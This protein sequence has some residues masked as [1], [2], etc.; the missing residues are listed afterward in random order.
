MSNQIELRQLESFLTL[1]KEL[2]FRR[3][4]E[5]LFISQPGLSKQM[6]QLEQQL[7]VT[8]LERDRRNVRLTASGVYL[9]TQ[10]ENILGLLDQTVTHIKHLENGLEGELKIGFV[11]SAMQQ[12]IP[13]LIKKCNTHYPNLRFVLDEMSNQAQVEAIQHYQIDLGFVRLNAVPSDVQLKPIFKEHFSLVLPKKHPITTRKFQGVHQLK[14]EPFILF[15][16]DY[17]SNYYNNIMSIFADAGFTPKVSHKS[18]HANTIFRLV[19]NG[20]GVAIVP[21]SLTLGATKAIAI[22]IVDLKK[23]RQRAVLSIAWKKDR[24]APALEKIL[25]FFNEVK[26]EKV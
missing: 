16:S 14:E 19:E 12:V 25:R 22:K 3:A 4:A 23:N 7:E 8:L 15:S 6:Q 9:K 24:H 13:D 20:L 11:G 18:I 26:Q 17:S 5:K 21:H 10:V 2:H 1:A